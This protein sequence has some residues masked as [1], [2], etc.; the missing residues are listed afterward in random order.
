M[1]NK[2][3]DFGESFTYYILH[4]K[5]FLQKTKSSSILKQ[6]YD[7]FGTYIFKKKEFF[8][9]KFNDEKV[10]DYYWDITKI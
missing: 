4:N 2:Y 8:D 5:D 9:T 3:E 1:T 6:K 7:F 10:K